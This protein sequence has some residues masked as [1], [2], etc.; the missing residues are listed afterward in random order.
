MQPQTA[1]QT[2]IKNCNVLEYL[3]FYV[4]KE[5]F[6]LFKMNT[7]HVVPHGKNDHKNIIQLQSY[8][9]LFPNQ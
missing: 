8:K 9:T 5:L 4:A 1:M 2:P 3:D 6:M 7:K